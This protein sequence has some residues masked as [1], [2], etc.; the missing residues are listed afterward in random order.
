MQNQDQNLV[1]F[2]YFLLITNTQNSLRF[3]ILRIQISPKICWIITNN[4]FKKNNYKRYFYRRSLMVI[5][6]RNVLQLV[7]NPLQ[8]RLKREAM[9]NLVVN[10][11]M[12]ILKRNIHPRNQNQSRHANFPPRRRRVLN[13][14]LTRTGAKRREER[15]E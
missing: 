6:R 1:I 3:L 10:R 2:E 15:K 11:A 8:R 9:M 5:R 7:R 12:G 14:I 4:M 13:P